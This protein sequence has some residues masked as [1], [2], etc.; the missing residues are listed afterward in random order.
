MSFAQRVGNKIQVYFVVP[1][2]F[3]KRPKPC[4]N[5]LGSVFLAITPDGTALPCHAARM[6]PGLNLPNVHLEQRARD[7]V[8]V[9]QAFNRF[10]GEGWMKEPCVS[11]PE[12]A[13]DFGG[14]RCQAYLLDR[15]CRQRRPGVRAVPAPPPGD[16]GGGARRAPPS[17]PPRAAREH[18]LNFRDHRISIAVT[19]G[20]P[21][22]PRGS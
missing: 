11:C 14:C 1:D 17:P 7:L 19:P 18:V 5:G 6:L 21:P 10:R 2:Y 4:M 20:A 22:Q 15:R 8:R 13:K 12:R 3:E 16:R 9:S